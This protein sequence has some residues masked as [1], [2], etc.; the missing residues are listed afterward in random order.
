MHVAGVGTD[1]A[2]GRPLFAVSA[3]KAGAASTLAIDPGVAGH[4][5][6]VAAAGS[7]AELPGGNSGAL[8]LAALAE[9]DSFGG[10]TI[11]NRF[12]SLA[13]DVGA[14]KLNAESEK[15]LRDDTLSLA[16]TMSQSASGVSLDEE[17][18]DMSK[19]Q[20]AF[21]AASK[22]LQTANELLANFLRDI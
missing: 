2:S 4:P 17:M 15:S 21:E 22:V 1:G 16:T 20:R 19:Y 3:T 14:R 6:R 18:I 11:T 8:A 7:V 5:E 12:A 13:S 9:S 10:T